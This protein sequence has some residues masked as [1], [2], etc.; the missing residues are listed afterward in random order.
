MVN[1]L[2]LTAGTEGKSK[3]WL[4]KHVHKYLDSDEVVKETGDLGGG[5]AVIKELQAKKRNSE[6]QARLNHHGDS[7]HSRQKR[8]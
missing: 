5:L 1:H 4:I 3:F 8:S 7:H 2:H 6:G